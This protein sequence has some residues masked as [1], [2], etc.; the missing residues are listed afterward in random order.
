MLLLTVGP[1]ASCLS[2]GWGRPLGLASSGHGWAVVNRK[3]R[4]P[5]VACT[6][7]RGSRYKDVAVHTVP[8]HRRHRLALA[9]V[10]ALCG[11]IAARGR[12]PGW[13]CTALNRAG[14]LLAWNAGFG[15]VREYIHYAVGSPVSGSSFAEVA[16][17]RRTT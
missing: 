17:R 12:T 14:R 9:C 2:A 7:F 15:P 6:Y 13:N 5:A 3:G 11:D 10:T 1:E 4:V 16:G 8:D